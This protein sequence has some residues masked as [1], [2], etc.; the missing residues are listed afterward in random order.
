M[1][2]IGQQK[3]SLGVMASYGA[4]KYLAEFFT[5]AFGALVFKYYETEIGLSS[6]YVALA[7]IIY[8]VWNA[9]ND[10]LI[11]YLTFKPT[12][13]AGRL[14]RRFPWIFFGALVWVFTFVLI[15]MVPSS[16]DASLKPLPVFLWMVVSTCLYD[17]L[18]SV[19]EVNYQSLFPDKFRGLKERNKTAGVST[20]IGVLGIAAGAILPTLIIEYGQPDTYLQNA[21]IFV[22]AGLA[23][24][25]LLIPGIREDKEMITRY[26]RSLEEQKKRPVSFFGELKE[27]FHERN[28]LA[29]IL[30]FFF[31]QSATMCMTGSVHYVGD[32]VL[33]GESSDTT[34]IF[35]GMLVGALL[36]VPFW[37]AM[38]KRL[39]DNQKML[40]ITAFAM[41]LFAFPMTFISSYTGFTIAMTLWGFG[42][43]GF[44]LMITPAMADVIDEI[45][46]KKGKREDGIYMGFRAFFG[47]LSYA[48]QALTFWAVH[49]LTRFSEDPRSP[50]AIFG[51]HIHMALAPTVFILVGILVFR[52][53][54]TLNRQKTDE[55]KAR[56]QELNL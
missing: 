2:I 4:G 19:W 20:V 15:F 31:Y 37:L 38:A 7:I 42:F 36:S 48:A 32:Y 24:I 8:S 18:Y 54:N 43:G 53:M 33:P 35:A 56:L 26:E 9:V 29:F 23:A 11:G 13:L 34:I 6:G 40:I 3:R 1:K 10:P 45:V 50:S 30:L 21:W 17:L 25:F 44:W 28:F 14:G 49:T 41:A 39:R 55:I 52:K 12:P 47:R 51:I 22:I 46:V 16:F 27:V 5:G